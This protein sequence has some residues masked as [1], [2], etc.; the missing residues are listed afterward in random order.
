MIQVCRYFRCARVF[1]T[2]VR[3][4][5][6]AGAQAGGGRQEEVEMSHR[7]DLFVPGDALQRLI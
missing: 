5:E 1:T 2:D 3:P 7:F 4:A 6:I